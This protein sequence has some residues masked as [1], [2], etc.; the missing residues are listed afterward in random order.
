[1]SWFP[2]I[3]LETRTINSGFAAFIDKKK[4]FI[5]HKSFGNSDEKRTSFFISGNLMDDLSPKV[6]R[7]PVDADTAVIGHNFSDPKR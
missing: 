5:L 3:A 1:L 2:A 4:N 6:L 7:I